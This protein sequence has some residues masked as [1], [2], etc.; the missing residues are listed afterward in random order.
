MLRVEVEFG[1]EYYTFRTNDDGCCLFRGLHTNRQIRN[2]SGYNSLYRIKRTIREL[3]RREWLD[4]H[5]INPPRIHYEY[6][7]DGFKK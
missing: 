2:D 6:I 3:L 1:G 4:A 7:S 5:D